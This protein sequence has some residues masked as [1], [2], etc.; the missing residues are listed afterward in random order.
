MEPYVDMPATAWAVLGV[1]SF[2]GDRSGYEV[3]S[4]AD[5][6]LRFFY[7]SPALSQVYRELRRL[8]EI[9]YATS[10]TAP[11]DAL[12]NKRL[13]RITDAG[14][15]AVAA[16][17]A[18]TPAAPPVLKHGVLLRVWL[19]HLL[20]HEDLR[21]VLTEHAAYAATMSQEAAALEVSAHRQQQ[22]PYP[23]LALRW[24]TR[25]YEAE[26]ALALQLLADL[27]E[28]TARL[29]SEPERG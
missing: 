17:A 21:A 19:G 7:W 15:A 3:K 16:W 20:S 9:G 2:P 12:R 10:Y 28:L 27:D 25:Y 24:S 26:R 22:W 8:E 29:A 23:E 13:Y 18:R 5:R 6:S 4:W 11:Q 14:R 1:L